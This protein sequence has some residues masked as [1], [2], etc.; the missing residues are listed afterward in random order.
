MFSKPS[1]LE[2]YELLRKHR[3]LLVHFSGTPKGSGAARPCNEYP[4]DLLNVI[5]LGAMGGLS[6]STVAPYDDFSCTSH[7]RKS[8]GS[9]GV[10]LGLKTPQSLIAAFPGDAGTLTDENDERAAH[11]R[12]VSLAE[13]EESIVNRCRY[14][15]WIVRDYTPLGILICSDPIFVDAREE[16]SGYDDLPPHLQMSSAKSILQPV[17]ISEQK[18]IKIFYPKSRVFKF[19][20]SGIYEWRNT[21]WREISHKHIYESC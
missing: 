12:T 3:A 18:V 20:D 14:N 10:I 4:D 7:E 8:T 2:V 19:K 11:D 5:A 13:L 17:E 15:E 21:E 16:L 1:I 9:V 6:S